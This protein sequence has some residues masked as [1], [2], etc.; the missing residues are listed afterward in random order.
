MISRTD[1]KDMT[2]AQDE[3]PS[4]LADLARAKAL[5]QQRAILAVMGVEPSTADREKPAPPAAM[6]DGGTARL[7]AQREH[8]AR[9]R[10]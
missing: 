3:A 2:D 4:L 7:E 6:K 10:G 9:R 5:F 8:D 1:I